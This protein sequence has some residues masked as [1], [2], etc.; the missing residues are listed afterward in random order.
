MSVENHIELI[1][2][3]VLPL[4]Q[5]SNLILYSQCLQ[6]IKILIKEIILKEKADL[7]QKDDQ[8]LFGKKFRSHVVGTERSKKKTLEEHWSLSFGQALHRTATNRVVGGDFTPVKKSNN[9]DRH[10]A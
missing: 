10:N 6:I 1:E 4:G 9:R 7:L 8:N 5:A 3:T 2:K